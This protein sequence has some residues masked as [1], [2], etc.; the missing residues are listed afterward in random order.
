MP[1]EIITAAKA[2]APGGPY[3]HAVKAGNLI[4]L[5]GQ[6]PKDPQ[7][8]EF[9]GDDI[10]TQTRQVFANL[11]VV[12]EAAGL[13]LGNVVR[14]GVFLADLDDFARMNAVY[15][16]TFEPYC[17]DGGFPARTTVQVGRFPPGMKIEVDVIATTK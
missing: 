16:E 8:G 1:K 12:L 7:T 4:F 6:V 3:S 11:A 13:D 5:S 14:C 10:E 15:Q 9:P 2:P 17:K